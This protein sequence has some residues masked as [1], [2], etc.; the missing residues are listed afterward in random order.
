MSGYREESYEIFSLSLYTASACASIIKRARNSRGWSDARVRKH[1]GDGRVRSVQMSNVRRARILRPQFA[2]KIY[3]DF[4]R[5]MD[6]KVKPL[7]KRI[8]QADLEEHTGT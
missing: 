8:W 1:M 5:R 3:D 6:Q 2:E 4:D 7:I